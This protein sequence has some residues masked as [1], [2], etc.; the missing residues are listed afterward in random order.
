[1]SDETTVLGSGMERK[2]GNGSQPTK[3]DLHC[4]STPTDTPE[5]RNN[6]L[7]IRKGRLCPRKEK[8]P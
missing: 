7:D 5:T 3:V 1:M 6:G 2:G 4:Y 8:G